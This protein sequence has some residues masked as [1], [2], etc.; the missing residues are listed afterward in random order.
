MRL[1]V[2]KLIA[3]VDTKQVE[4]G[5]PVRFNFSIEGKGNFAAIPAPNLESS[6]EFKIG[7]PGFL[8]Q[9]DEKSKFEGKQSFE[10][11][12]TPIKSG[13]ITLPSINFAYFD[14]N[15]E[16]YNTISTQK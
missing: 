12:I 16:K 8:F 10:Y 13:S 15:L 6:A 3:S 2:F 1:V 14:P 5:D 7:P 4:I 9:G 11:I